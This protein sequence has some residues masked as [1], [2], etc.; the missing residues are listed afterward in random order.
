MIILYV[1]LLILI[2]III[3]IFYSWI[4]SEVTPLYIPFNRNIIQIDES[5]NIMRGVITD[6]E[7]YI[8][9]LKTKVDSLETKNIELINKFNTLYASIGEQVVLP[10][11]PYSDPEIDLILVI[12]KRLNDYI[13]KEYVYTNPSSDYIR[14]TKFYDEILVIIQSY[15]DSTTYSLIE[16]K[17]K[18]DDI[19]LL[20]FRESI[21]TIFT[22][23]EEYDF[24]TF[25]N[26]IKLIINNE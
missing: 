13:D 18:Y 21:D 4:M 12:A 9:T 3:L 25:N 22:T 19:S 7:L 11:V 23:E 20:S 14:G 17:N 2:I 5:N 1:L 8:N 6:L 15:Y 16:F 24:D 10:P 26:E